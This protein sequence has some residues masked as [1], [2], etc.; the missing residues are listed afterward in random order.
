MWPVAYAPAHGRAPLRRVLARYLG[1]DEAELSLVDDL[2]GRPALDG[3]PPLRFNW[4]HS[5][6]RALIAVA[7]D[8]QPGID[9]EHRQRRR[10]R[11]VLALA[12]RFFSIE[13]AS[14]LAELEQENRELAFLRMWTAKEALLKAHGRGLAFGLARVSVDVFGD[15][16]ALRGFAGEEL[17]NWQL[18]ALDAGAEH[19]AAL[20]WRGPS[21]RVRWIVR[22]D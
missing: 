17:A 5:G 22:A 12:R 19:V 20:A 14:A 21:Q 9:L 11:D 3:D 4:S 2:H 18:R 16:P 10:P 6:D 1:R 7:R 15:A 8:V 13:E